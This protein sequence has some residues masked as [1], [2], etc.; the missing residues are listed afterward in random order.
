MAQQNNGYPPYFPNP[1]AQMSSPP[2]QMQP[3]QPQ[4]QPS[5]SSIYGGNQ[6]MPVQ[7]IP[8]RVVQSEEEIKP[9][10][11]PM[12]LTIALFPKSDYSCIY[13]RQWNRNGTID[14]VKY[15]PEPRQATAM[16]STDDGFKTAVFERLDKIEQLLN[17]KPHYSKPN[18]NKPRPPKKEEDDG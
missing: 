1:G 4:Q 9:N 14:P 8:G 17:R 13:A 15:V 18:Y 3:P 10:E 6:Q 16:P 7:A 5:L 11:V 2:M 12:D